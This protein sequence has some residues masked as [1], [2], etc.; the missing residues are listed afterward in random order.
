MGGST[1]A[2][3][4]TR[5][6]RWEKTHVS[7]AR[8]N[9][10]AEIPH[11]R[12]PIILMIIAWGFGDFAPRDEPRARKH[13]PAHPR[14]GDFSLGGPFF[15]GP[16]CVFWPQDGCFLRLKGDPGEVTGFPAPRSCERRDFPSRLGPPWAPRLGGAV[17]PSCRATRNS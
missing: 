17:P 2:K 8:R 4:P 7:R 14:R 1:Q 10:N 15:L 3:W 16:L 9:A 5:K 11:D 13:F 6:R 12:H